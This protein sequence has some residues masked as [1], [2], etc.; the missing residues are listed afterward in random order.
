[1]TRE[2]SP[3]LGANT[4]GINL[5]TA[6]SSWYDITQE[7]PQLFGTTTVATRGKRIRVTST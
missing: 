4:L 3:Q 5:R 2:A 7:T 1:M 6:F